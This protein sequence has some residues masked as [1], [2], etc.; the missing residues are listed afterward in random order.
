MR[1]ILFILLILLI[2]PCV[3]SWE[4]ITFNNS[5]SEENLTFT[6]SEDLIRWLS[7]PSDYFITKGFLNLSGYNFG[8]N[9]TN[10]NFSILVEAS[11]SPRGLAIHNENFYVADATNVR[12]YEFNS[13]GDYTG[14]NVSVFNEESSP[15]GLTFANGNFYMVGVN[16]DRVYEYNSTLNLTG[17][18]FTVLNEMSLASGITFA[19][20]NFYIADSGTDRVYEYNI[21]GSHTG[22]DFSIASQASTSSGIT[23]VDVN[24]NFYVTDSGLIKAFEYNITGSYTGFSFDLSQAGTSPGGTIYNNGNIYITDQNTDKITAFSSEI[25]NP[26]IKIENNTIWT[27]TG[28][29]NQTNNRTTNLASTINKFLNSTYLIG[30]NYL[31]PFTFHSDTAGILQYLDLNFSDDIDIIVESDCTNPSYLFTFKD[32]ENLTTLDG[33]TINYNF[34]YGINNATT[35]TIYGTLTN[36]NNFSI[37]LNST[38]GFNWSIGSGEIHYSINNYIDRR[39]YLYDGSIATNITNN[40]ILYNLLSSRQTSFK[41]EVEDT[42]LNPYVDKYTT[43]LRWYPQLNEYSVVEMGKTDENG[44]TVIHVR[45]EDVDYRIGVYERNGSLIKLEDPTRFV[46]LVDPCTYTLKISP[47]DTDFTSFYD[48]DFTFTYN[49]TSGIWLFTY[50]DSSQRT[51]GMN[52]TIYKVTGTSVFPICSDSDTSYTGAITC[53]TSLYSGTLKG[54]VLR[55]ASPDIPFTQ[56]IITTTQTAFSSSFGLWLSLLIGIPIAFLFALMSPIAAV[57]G[58]VIMLLPALYFGSV[59]WAIVGGVAVLGGIVMHFL[60]RIG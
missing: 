59:N 33:A 23:Y 29:F 56:K 51:S 46:C 31:I 60:K 50:S 52:L 6:G 49:A 9:V 3:S 54:I 22:F 45:T 14:F 43:L 36:A 35:K 57:V 13:T 8:F 38:E 15:S 40:I 27:F 41:L 48:V 7:I 28:E 26:S 24:N 2:L 55:S 4:E 19:N 25:N 1:K 44:E 18:N 47:T 11:S 20:N 12:I 16:K 5:L 34:Q 58:G 42:S 37:C 53:D 30:S 17:F 32:E 10:F 21:T 39:Y